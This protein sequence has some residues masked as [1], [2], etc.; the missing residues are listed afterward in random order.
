M[1]KRKRW[2]VVAIFVVVVAA[3]VVG[4]VLWFGRDK[5]ASVHY[6][7]EKVTTGTISQTVQADFTLGSANGPTSVALGGGA[8]SGTASNATSST[9]SPGRRA[10]PATT[11]RPRARR[12]SPR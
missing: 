3:V 10:P 7:T 5:T 9:S 4:G 1:K 8:A 2:V 12:P 6:L 11:T